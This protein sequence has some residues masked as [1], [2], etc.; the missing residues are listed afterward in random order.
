MLEIIRSCF[1]ESPANFYSVLSRNNS[2]VG[3]TM[4][5]IVCFEVVTCGLDDVSNNQ[6]KCANVSGVRI[7]F[8]NAQTPKVTFLVKFIYPG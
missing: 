4:F 5:C 3:M 7:S 6:L 2:V 8:N 1:L